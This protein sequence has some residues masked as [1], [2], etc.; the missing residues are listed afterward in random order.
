MGVERCPR[1]PTQGPVASYCGR[2]IHISYSGEDKSASVGLGEE[3][4]SVGEIIICSVGEK[5]ATVKAEKRNL[6]SVGV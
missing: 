4:A 5:S 6:A 1:A 3:S 2:Q